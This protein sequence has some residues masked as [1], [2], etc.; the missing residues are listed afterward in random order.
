MGTINLITDYGA[1]IEI[2]RGIEGLLHVSE[3]SLS[4]KSRSPA[5][6]YNT[7]DI[8]EVIILS[9]DT[10]KRKISLGIDQNRSE[11]KRSIKDP[12]SFGSINIGNHV[13]CKVT[14]IELF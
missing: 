10:T 3:M 12:N 7:D 11:S 13:K 2:S 9:V 5:D 8:I 4:K 6:Y 14:K 1:F